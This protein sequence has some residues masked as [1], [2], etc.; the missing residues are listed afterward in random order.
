MITPLHATFTPRAAR[1]GAFWRP[2]CNGR[3]LDVSEQGFQ[4]K[5][6]LAALHLMHRPENAS[7]GK[8]SVLMQWLVLDDLLYVA[9]GPDACR[10]TLAC[11]KTVADTHPM[12][13]TVRQV[14]SQLQQHQTQP[15][16]P[17][18]L[19]QQLCAVFQAV[20]A[21]AFERIATEQFTAA[22]AQDLAVPN[23]PLLDILK[24]LHNGPGGPDPENN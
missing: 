12:A 9:T 19:G 7:D 10:Y 18:L 4:S 5:Q 23:D 14:I 8:R 11:L 15:L 2:L 21:E 22:Q 3:P 13:K 6:H 17:N 20:E 24:A 16:L 1:F